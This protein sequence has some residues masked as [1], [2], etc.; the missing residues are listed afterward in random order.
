MTLEISPARKTF[1]KSKLVHALISALLLSVIGTSPSY[2]G[3][4]QADV[5]YSQAMIALTGK[6]QT[7]SENFSKI[8]TKPPT[9]AVG[10]SYNAWKVKA[11]KSSSEMLAVI[12][13]LSAVQGTDGFAKSHP[14]LTK[15]LANF[16]TGV[17]LAK[18]AMNKNDS[19][20]MAKAN[21]ALLK[22]NSGWVAWSAAYE[23]DVAALNG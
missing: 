19:K 16:K 15:A 18:A 14:L 2:A 12:S 1:A 11:I 20:K 7:A 4:T 9:W 8:A 5:D 22:G 21:A 3:A 10:K 13:E 6:F 23:A 17:T